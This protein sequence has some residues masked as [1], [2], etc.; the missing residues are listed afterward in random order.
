M[1]QDYI[2]ASQ[3]YAN[4]AKNKYEPSISY[5]LNGLDE[6]KVARQ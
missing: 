6:V 4:D 2:N 1:N 3:N 5:L